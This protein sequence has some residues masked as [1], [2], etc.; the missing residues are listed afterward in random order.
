MGNL[1]HRTRRHRRPTIALTASVVVAAGLTGCTLASSP[2][3]PNA[4]ATALAAG[5]AQ[6]DLTK[7]AF[8]GATA[9]DAT[10]FVKTAVGDLKDVKR[11]VTVSKV[12]KTQGNDKLATASLAYTWDVDESDK[13]WTYSTDAVLSLGQDKTWHVTWSPALLAP[14]LT[15]TEHLVSSYTQAKRADIIGANN[16]PL[17]TERAV[18]QIGIDKGRIDPAQAPSSAAA[19]AGLLG[20]D[21]VAYSKAVTSAGAKAFV[22]ALTLRADDPVATSKADAIAAVPG[23]VRIPGKSS[24]GPSPTFARALL[25]TVGP[26]TAEIVQG[27]AGKVLTGDIVGL[28]GLQQRYDAQLGGAKGLKIQ[29]VGTDAAGK[30]SA[31]DL[32]TRDPV[33]GKPLTISLDPAAQT[34]AEAALGAVTSTPTA[35]VAIRPSTGEILAAANG[36]ATN[37]Q[38]LATTGHAAPGSTFKIVSALALLRAG[39]TPD[40]VV[41]CT[42]TV[43]VDGRTFKNYNDYPPD[44]VG[45]IPF[46]TAFANSCNTAFISS[47]DKISQAD[48]TSAAASLGIG[49]DLDLGFP[50]FLGSVPDKAQGTERA[51]SMIGQAKIEVA[52]MDMATVVASVMKGSVA[53]PKLIMD[54]PAAAAF[55]APAKPLQP[56]EAQALQAL[57]GAVVSEGSGRAL[58]G[59]GVT[60]AKTGT[61]EYGTQT[62]PKTHA[63]MAAGKGD[64]AV[65]AYVEDGVS[66]SQSAAPLIK[67]FLQAYNG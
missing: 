24:L 63:W 19:L 32:F 58:A 16:T 65:V 66:G 22:I 43:V 15:A 9:A 23:A 53:R 1:T 36:P 55:P 30:P 13:D 56:A 2:P 8:D 37:G 3:E 17:V 20:M 7:V 14:G 54:N 31:R 48:L 27:S 35:L 40:T 61:A 12:A 21:S 47:K 5:L 4:A 46:R 59:V 38:A 57:M 42:P 60:L 28:S 50:A 49:V 6:G 41:P 45:Q 52:P 18:F 44:R 11:T 67:A 10:A 64:L 26:A 34:A 39:I 25:G 62:P 51:A 29:A 33:P